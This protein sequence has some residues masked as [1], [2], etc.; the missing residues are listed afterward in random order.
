MGV[1]SE[2]LLG[3]GAGRGAVGG[4]EEGEEAEVFGGLFGGFADDGDVEAVADGFGDVAE[5]DSFFGDGVVAVSGVALLNREAVERGGVEQVGD[6]LSLLK[7]RSY[8]SGWGTQIRSST[9]AD[10]GL[11]CCTCTLNP[12]TLV[13]GNPSIANR[14]SFPLLRM[15]AACR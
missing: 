9:Q 6:V 10:G 13:C 12:P 5:G 4:D 7:P 11:E 8:V 14:R 15:T 2:A 1:P 3:L